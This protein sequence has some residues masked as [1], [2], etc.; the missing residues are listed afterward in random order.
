[1]NKLKN[2]IVIIFALLIILTL[3]LAAINKKQIN[4]EKKI[5]ED[6]E[7]G[8]EF[9]TQYTKNGFTNVED[10]SIFFTVT[11]CIQNYLNYINPENNILG[12]NKEFSYTEEEIENERKDILYDLL[13]KKYISKNG[14]T[15]ENVHQ[16]V[17]NIDEYTIFIPKKIIE[18]ADTNIKE[19]I[20]EGS[21][22]NSKINDKTYFIVY[23]DSQ[24]STYSIEP[25]QNTDNIENIKVSENTENIEDNVYNV[26]SYVNSSD[27]DTIERYIKYIVQIIIDSPDEL[28]N[29]YLNEDYKSEKFS[30]KDNFDKYISRNKEYIEGC[31]IKKYKVSEENNNTEYICLDQYGNYY[32]FDEKSVMDFKVK[33]DNY[34]ID[35]T[36]FVNKYKTRNNET[37]VKMNLEKVV[38]A[39]NRKDYEY[40]YSKLDN[41]FKQNNFSTIEEFENYIKNNFYNIN[42]AKYEDFEDKTDIYVYKV[43]LSDATEENTDVVEKSFIMKLED[44][45]NYS[46]SFNI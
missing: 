38:Q 13:D 11:D 10:K 36:E 23:L 15:T 20:L 6:K 4:L 27:E 29:N 22:L 35:S 42:K 31:I 7:T 33:L 8:G 32:I 16:Y 19:Y 28:Y 41:S 3:V 39:L 1:M 2:V 30:L 44:E 43:T 24:N 46:I 40:V 45:R 17:N 9:P 21:I 5:E 37:K 25:I 34:T 12:Y 14:I 26:Y 18:K